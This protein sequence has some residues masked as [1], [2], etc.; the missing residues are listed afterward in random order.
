M[1]LR[2]ACDS[3]NHGFWTSGYAEGFV[4]LSILVPFLQQ[5][6][7]VILNVILEEERSCK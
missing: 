3:I 5:W 4:L 1:Y 7:I 2:E 6:D